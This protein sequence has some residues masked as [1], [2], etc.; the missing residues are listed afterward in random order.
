MKPVPL[1]REIQAQI[2][3][4]LALVKIPAWRSNSGALV[5]P[6][7]TTTARRFVRFNGAQ[8][9][10][11]ILGVIP[12]SGRMLAVEVKRPGQLLTAK[13]RGFLDMVQAAGGLAVCVTS[14]DEL[15][16]VLK[17]EGVLP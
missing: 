11:D 9:C 3:Q 1:E 10:A 15:A 8:G 5:A 4:W 17:V 7:T 12:P 6:A 2:L 14:V 13:Q 16:A